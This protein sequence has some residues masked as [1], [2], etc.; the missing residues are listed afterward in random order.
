MFVNFFAGLNTRTTRNAFEEINNTFINYRKKC[1][2]ILYYQYIR[3]NTCHEN[4]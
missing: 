4:S 3:N 1:S 2:N